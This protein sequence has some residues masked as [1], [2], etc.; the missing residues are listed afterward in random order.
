MDSE[1][2]WRAPKLE[3]DNAKVYANVAIGPRLT[4]SAAIPGTKESAFNMETRID[5]PKLEI[6]AGQTH[7]ACSFTAPFPSNTTLTPRRRDRDVHPSDAR[8]GRHQERV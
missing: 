5:M 6:A 4:L 1:V 3:I 7:S 8:R 2:T